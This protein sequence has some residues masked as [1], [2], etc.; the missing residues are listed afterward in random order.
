MNP[1]LISLRIAAV[2]YFVLSAFLIGTG[3]VIDN[4]ASLLFISLFSIGFGYFILRVR[5]GLIA[6]K[7]WAWVAGI[8][9][10]GM[11]VFSLFFPLGIM[12]LMGLLNTK[13]RQAFNNA[14]DQS[15][16]A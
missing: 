13:T 8:I 15:V 14:A 5:S 9:I 16:V 3:L 6:G 12:G 1:A 10:S 11:Q 7:Y 2:L 4:G